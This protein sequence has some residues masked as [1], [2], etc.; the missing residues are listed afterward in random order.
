MK[1]TRLL[2][3]WSFVLSFFITCTALA[4]PPFSDDFD[5][6][7]DVGWI[8]YE[9]LAGLAAGGVGTWSFPTGAYRLQ[10]TAAVLPA[11][12][13]PARVGGYPTNIFTEFEVRMDLAHWPTNLDQLF[14]VTSRIIQPGRGT[15]DG[16][17][18]AFETRF[19]RSPTGRLQIL[20]L[21]NEGSSVLAFADLNLIPGNRYRFIFTGLLS[22]L[23]GQLFDLTNAATPVTTLMATDATYTSGYCGLFVYDSGTG[24]NHPVDF[25]VDNFGAG[26]AAPKLNITIDGPTETVFVT[27]PSWGASFVLESSTD[28]V[29]WDPVDFD[30]VLNGDVFEH[31][32]NT[33]HQRHFYRLVSE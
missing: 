4:V 31:T 16:Y 18:F 30:V 26:P 13:G 33:F 6:G 2:F 21:L 1:A 28:L 7:N 27:W 14:G 10:A 29:T 25:T 5:D 12:T 23:K 19:G 15:T 8:H 32:G 17:A 3:G 20:R 11:Q 22:Q 9:P 24:G